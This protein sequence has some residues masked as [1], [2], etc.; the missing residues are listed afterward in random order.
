MGDQSISLAYIWAEFRRSRVGLAG[1]TILFILL[2][3]SIIAFTSTPLERLKEWNNPSAWTFYPRS[4]MPAWVNVLS[5]SKQPEHLILERPEVSI[6]DSDSL[7]IVTHRYT[8]NYAYDEFPSDFMLNYRIRYEGSAPLLLLTITRP[9]KDSIELARVSLPYASNE[10]VYESTL[11]S[12]DRAVQDGIANNLSKYRFSIS[13]DATV[14]AVFSSYEERRVMKG[15]Y[16]VEARFFL[17]DERDEVL[18]SRF[19]VGGKVYG[20]LGTDDLRRDLSIGLIWGAPIAL[21]IGISVASISVLIGMVYGIISGYKGG[22]TD[23]V[24]MRANDVVY[25]LPAL[26]LLIL[27]AVSVGRSILLIVAYNIWMGRNSKGI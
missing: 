8:F 24:M 23:E 20:L 21:F 10:Q 2:A 12:T 16:N 3:V 22:S 17:F 26:P 1:L 14:T 11:F 9:D 25:A 15:V 27:L 4:A 13:R 18:A 6:E 7:R 5:S 19:I